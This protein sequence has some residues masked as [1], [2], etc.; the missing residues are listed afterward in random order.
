MRVAVLFLRFGPYHLARLE[1][2][3]ERLARDGDELIGIEIAPTSHVYTWDTVTGGHHFRKVTLFEDRVHEDIPKQEVRSAV[4][5][6]LEQVDPTMVALPGWS[7]RESLAALHWA[8]GRGVPTIMMSASTRTDFARHWWS[9]RIKCGVVRCCSAGLVGGQRHADYMAELGMERDRI[10]PGYDVVDNDYF[11][12]GADHAREQDAE[13]RERY[14]LPRRYFLVS[15]RFVPKKNLARLLTAYARYREAAGTTAWDLVLCGDGPLRGEL[16]A[17]VD[18]MDL[19]TSVHF[20]GFVQY[21]ELPEYYGLASAF[22]LASTVEQWGLVVNEAASA[23]LALLVSDRCGCAPELVVD[24]R[25]G[26]VLDPLDEAGI[27]AA[28][29]RLSD[30]PE[31]AARMGQASQEIVSDFSPRRFADE[32]VSAAVCAIE[33]PRVNPTVADRMIV[34]L[35]ATLR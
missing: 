8:M 28:M 2:A 24:G 9:E 4:R 33:K 30:D 32:L 29:Q 20:P 27:A 18:H 12:T 25:N 23:G 17:A 10:F 34:R 14:H 21:G 6:A 3:G 22:V 15:S 16:E 35:M 5:T 19:R 1:A 31:G 13:L 26:Y 7:C 11:R